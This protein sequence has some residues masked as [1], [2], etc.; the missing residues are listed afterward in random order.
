[1]G[2]GCVACAR[3][4]AEATT[5]V[6]WAWAGRGAGLGVSITSRASSLRAWCR[7]Q[8][9]GPPPTQPSQRTPPERRRVR[10]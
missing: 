7:T 10:G 6:G 1:M 2:W 8:P 9:R 4:G 5:G 3:V